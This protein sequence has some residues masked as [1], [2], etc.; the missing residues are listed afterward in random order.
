MHCIYRD[1]TLNATR[2]GPPITLVPLMG[3]VYM[4][5]V[6]S[7]VMRRGIFVLM[8]LKYYPLAELW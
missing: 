4:F 1:N 7:Y 8:C 6:L 2:E 5:H 3:Q